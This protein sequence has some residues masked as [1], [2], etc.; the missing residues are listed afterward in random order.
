[1]NNIPKLNILYFCTRFHLYI[2]VYALLLVSR[3][4]SLLQISMIESVVIGTVFLMEVPTGI[5][6]DRLGRKGS[7]VASTV[8][9]MGGELLFLFS[10]TYALYL[11]VAVLTGTG[12]AFASGAVEALI[13]D[14]LPPQNRQERMKQVMGRYGSIGQIAFFLS[15][16]VGGLVVADLTPAR[17]TL[18]IAL[19]VAVLFVGVLVSLTLVEPPLPYHTQRPDPLT[20]F[21]N[22]VKTLHGSRPLRRLMLVA[23]LTTSFN[24]TLI[25][26]LAA[27]YLKLHHV[28]PFGIGLALSIGSLLA[29]VMQHNAYHVEKRIGLLPLILLPGVSYLV[30]A[31]VRNPV[32]VWGMVV[33]L[34]GI[35]DM[36]NPLFSAYQNS[37]I[38]TESRATTLSLMNVLLNLFIAV[39]SPVYAMLAQI[40]LPLAFIAM[41]SV[42]LVAGLTL[43]VDF[44][45]EGG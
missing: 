8:L 42:I 24:G 10:R 25:T 31:G 5:L 37:L 7:M 32:L 23:I 36:K 21:R 20:I 39:M 16:I 33:W 13:Y 43:R 15:P 34:Y 30:L 6:A 44:E 3:G 35:N 17:F 45:I 29:A 41:G 4:L 18:A 1:M 2:H 38:T 14:S 27:P 28:P 22:G 9:L 12:F 40:S 19:T 26:T 11:V